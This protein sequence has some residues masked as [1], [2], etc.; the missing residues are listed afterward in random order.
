MG[1][2]PLFDS[3][4]RGT[5]YG[6]W[7]DIGL[8]PI[9]LA[10][11]DKDGIVD[12]TP[13]VIAGITGLPVPEVEACMDRFCQPDK[14][15]RT[16]T[17][18]GRRLVLLDPSR[19]WGWR[20]VN[21]AYYREKARLAAKNAREIET[22]QNRDRMHDRRGPPETAA[23]RQGPPGTASQTQTQTQTEDGE[24]R[25]RR[26]TRLPDGFA[27]TPERRAYAERE[28]I[29]AQREFDKFRDH[30]SQAGGSNARKHDWDAAW[31]LWCRRAADDLSRRPPPR[32]P[33]GGGA[34][35]PKTQEQLKTEAKKLAE[36]GGS[37]SDIAKWLKVPQHT[38]EEWLGKSRSEGLKRFAT[39]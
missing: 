36:A 15:S 29:D 32:G 11:A 37:A 21:H 27:L 5:L 35:A 6:R 28:G 9:V 7:P 10:L 1:Y 31:R 16:N 25:A 20:V 13:Q 33:F 3:I 38:V 23:D 18:D 17:E 26:A 12:A 39:R 19:R 8:W 4:T 2:T 24:G 34:P 30:W 22:G 14:A